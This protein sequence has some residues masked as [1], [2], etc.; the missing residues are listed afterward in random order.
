M[1]KRER[2]LVRVVRNLA[3]ESSSMSDEKRPLMFFHVATEFIS[4]L[5]KLPNRQVT[6][7]MTLN[8]ESEL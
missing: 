2:D 5:P 4:L 7:E 8:H 6:R 1:V 3:S